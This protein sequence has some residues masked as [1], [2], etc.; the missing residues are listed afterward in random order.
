MLDHVGIQCRDVAVA[1]AFYAKVLATVGG[2]EVMRPVPDV[3]GYGV[4]GRPTFWIGPLSGTAENRE[5]HICFEAP[6]RAAVRA[7][8]A[9]AEEAGAEV[10]HSARV[11]PEYHPDYYGAFVRDPEGNNVEACC[12]RPE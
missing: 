3:V 11:F 10:L 8:Q 12:H 1:S 6:D 7:F 2:A 9:A 5:L 4:G